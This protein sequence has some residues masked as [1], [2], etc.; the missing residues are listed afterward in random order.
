MSSFITS[1]ANPKQHFPTV[2]SIVCSNGRFSNV[3]QCQSIK[4]RTLQRRQLPQDNNFQRKIAPIQGASW[5]DSHEKGS[6]TKARH[7]HHLLSFACQINYTSPAVEMAAPSKAPAMRCSFMSWQRNL[8]F[9]LPLELAC[10][11]Y[12]SCLLS[13]PSVASAQ[14]ER[15]FSSL[16]SWWHGDHL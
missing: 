6:E 5:S 12:R 2:L 11:I 1:S 9:Y 8:F 3:T 7:N 10:H 4:M 15:S 14:L 16:K 13:C